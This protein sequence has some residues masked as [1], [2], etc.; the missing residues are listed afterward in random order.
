MERTRRRKGSAR[1]AARIVVVDSM[2]V[3]ESCV[4]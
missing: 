4:G 1:M 3:Q 2:T